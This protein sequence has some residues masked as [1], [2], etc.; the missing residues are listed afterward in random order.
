MFHF[1]SLLGATQ[2]HDNKRLQTSWST[3]CNFRTENVQYLCNR[4][5]LCNYL[6][7]IVKCCLQEPWNPF[8]MILLSDLYIILLTNKHTFIKMIYNKSKYKWNIP[9]VE[10]IKVTC[11]KQWNCSRKLKKRCWVHISFKVDWYI[12][13]VIVLWFDK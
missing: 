10:V 7:D 1:I 12:C 13:R 8:P 5:R 6:S 4:H 3:T 9:F 11:Q 2:L